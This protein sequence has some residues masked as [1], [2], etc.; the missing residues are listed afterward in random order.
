[1]QAELDKVALGKWR[2]HLPLILAVLHDAERRQVQD[3]GVESWMDDLKSLAFNIEDVLDEIHTEAKRSNFT[4]GL[5]TSTRKIWKLIPFLNCSKLT[6][7]MKIG[8]KMT[9]ITRE[10]DDIVA[11]I[12]LLRLR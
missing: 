12:P 10:M 6:F 1:M 3:D 11:R 4:E 7:N 8:E 2:K 9:T 5:E